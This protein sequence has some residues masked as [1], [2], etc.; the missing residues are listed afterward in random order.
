MKYGLFLLLVG[1]SF[2][3]GLG[4]EVVVRKDVAYLEAGRKEKADVYTPAGNHTAPLPAVLLIHGG[5]WV[6]G[7]KA[8]KRGVSIA[9]DLA[10]AGYLVFAINYKLT[11]R[12]GAPSH[13]IPMVSIPS[14]PQN[15]YDCKSALRYMR[16]EAASLGIDPDRIA[17]MGESAGGHLALLLG[18]TAQVADLNK[19]GLYTDQRND[20]AC[21]VDLYGVPDLSAPERA[22]QLVNF[23]GANDAE[24]AE[25]VR[26]A[27]P[28]TY[29]DAKTPPVL[30]L[31]GTVDTL[32]PIAASRQLADRLKQLGVAYQFVEIPGMG[33]A[34]DL[35]PKQLDRSNLQ[36]M[37]MDLRPVVFDFLE[38]YLRKKG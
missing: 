27:S 8:D 37:S 5:G 2:L 32:V 6:K 14:W 10:G 20:V 23:A 15:L 16:K 24:T 13:G 3:R 35:K 1:T 33:H 38:K 4:D 25:N 34:F 22:K 12:T 11:E 17:V 28:V 36:S 31:H 19:G 7:D 30:I 18:S 26:R 21:V 9:T 29:L